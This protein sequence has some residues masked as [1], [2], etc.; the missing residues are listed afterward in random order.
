MKI[1]KVT[2]YHLPGT[3]YPWVFIRIDTDEG[4]RPGTTAERFEALATN[5]V[6]P[7]RLTK[8]VL[9]A[10]AA[11]AREGRGAVVV[12]VSSDAAVNAYPKW[13]AYSVGKAGLRHLSA[14]WDAELATDGVRLLSIDPGDM[15]TPLHAAVG[16]DDS[17]WKILCARGG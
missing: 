15:D 11:S 17:R 2:T 12:N 6:G 16:A 7:F 9:G 3:R 4:V 1:T 5:L 10:L 13:G 8:A 14:V